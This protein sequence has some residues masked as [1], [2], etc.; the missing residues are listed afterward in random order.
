MTSL[1]PESLAKEG[2]ES[3]SCL[4][5]EAFEH[6]KIR[7]QQ[8]LQLNDELDKKKEHTLL[9][10]EEQAREL[11]SLAA[12]PASSF[13][14]KSAGFNQQSSSNLA[15]DT[16]ATSIAGDRKLGSASRIQ[17]AGAR[18]SEEPTSLSGSPYSSGVHLRNAVLKDP[19]TSGQQGKSVQQEYKKLVQLG[20]SSMGSGLTCENLESLAATVRLQ[21]SRILALQEELEARTREVQRY[22]QDLHAAKNRNKELTDENEK[23]KRKINQLNVQTEK[24]K[25][26]Q[27]EASSKLDGLDQIIVEL[28]SE[29]DKLTTAAKKNAAELNNKDVRLNRA[30][31]EVE[32]LKQQ[33]KEWR[34]G[35]KDRSAEQ[36]E[37]EKLVAD[38][39]KLENQRN[40]LILGF[41]KQMKLIDILKKQKAH[42]EAARLLSF[43]EDEFLKI[44]RGEDQLGI[45]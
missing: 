5:A 3:P 12:K 19:Y 18:C 26:A 17:T 31:E 27:S 23:L 36:R 25:K 37:I 45:N 6:F 13:R 11:S 2:D 24:S 15:Q 43:T 44:L 16:C 32:T 21:K 42:M 22:E 29:N 34:C 39:K 8:L 10:A 40:E 30:V 7:E 35:S 20:C 14:P 33:L 4:P 28:R 9:A 1:P 38:N 41:K